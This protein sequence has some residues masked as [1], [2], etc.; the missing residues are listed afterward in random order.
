MKFQKIYLL[1]PRPSL[2]LLMSAFFPQKQCFRHEVIVQF[3]WRFFFL[4]C[5]VTG[6]H[7]MLISWLALELWQFSF[8][9]DW[10]EI[11]KSE[12]HPS[13]FWPISR[14]WGKVGI[15]DLAWMSL[16]ECYW[17][18]QNATVTTLTGFEL[19]TENQQGEESYPSPPTQIRVKDFDS[20]LYLE[21]HQT[22]IES[23]CKK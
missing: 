17:M 6:L 21:T 20:E 18:L 9:K 22:M 23:F 15:P 5:L 12:I 16:V 3:F 1:V 7:F 13:E 11:R 10:P 19:L 8:I 4:P 2:I 14:D